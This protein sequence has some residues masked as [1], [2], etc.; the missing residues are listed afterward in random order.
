M[1]ASEKIESWLKLVLGGL[2]SHPEQ[3]TIETK[4]D[5]QGVL[6]TIN[7]HEDDRG[8]IIGQKGSIAEALRVITRSAGRLVDIRVSVKIEAPGSRFAPKE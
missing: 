3:I 7:A 8:K 4:I 5:E 1:E 2:V 6:F